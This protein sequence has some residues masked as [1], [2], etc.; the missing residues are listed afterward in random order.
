MCAA[1]SVCVPG[2]EVARNGGESRGSFGSLA[3]QPMPGHIPTNQPV[4][5]AAHALESTNVFE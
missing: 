4:F 2:K 3:S 1:S 5:R